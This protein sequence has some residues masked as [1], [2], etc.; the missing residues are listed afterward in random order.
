M[1]PLTPSLPW[2]PPESAPTRSRQ[3]SPGSSTT[4]A[5]Y[6]SQ[7]ASTTRGAGSL[8]PR[9]RRRRR[10]PRSFRRNGHANNLVARLE[11]TEQ[12]T[13]CLGRG[14]WHRTNLDAFDQSLAL[15]ALAA[16]K[17]W[18]AIRLGETLPGRPAVHRRGLGV[19]PD[20]EDA[21]CATPNPKNYSSPDTNTTALA[22]MATIAA[23]GHFAHSPVTF[24]Q[25]PR[26][27]TAP[28]AST[29]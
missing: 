2:L 20:L 23:G 24:F 26:R 5:S 21:P 11:A 10:R 22:V 15:L 7:R 8:D 19:Q 16:T 25:A 9:R 1:T 14:F 29:A 28:S 12:L 17:T 3:P 13:G 18:Q 27:P 4:Y 6:V